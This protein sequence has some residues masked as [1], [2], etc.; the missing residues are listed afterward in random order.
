MNAR[1]FL[2]RQNS[3]KPFR[4]AT[5]ARK[6][7]SI[8]RRPRRQ[9]P[10]LTGLVPR[11]TFP[12]HQTVWLEPKEQDRL[13]R[14]RSLSDARQGNYDDAIEG[15]TILI[16]RNPEGATD[17]NN[18]GLVHFQQG[19]LQAALDDYT[20]AIKLN[21]RLASAYNNRANY[22]AAQG[23]LAEAIADYETAIDLDPTNIRAWINQGIT[24]R[25]LEMYAQ[26]IENFEQA[27]QI[28]HLL[29]QNPEVS[30][31]L[32]AHI[33]GAQGR[34]HHLAGDWNL[35]IADYYRALDRFF[36]LELD[37]TSHRLQTQI[38]LWLGE[39]QA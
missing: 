37:L 31:R 5:V 8:A 38:I 3:D 29:G 23:N 9:S 4:A 12:T 20:Q 2:N 6:G 34:T 1:T 19:Q 17:Y 21:P 16:D 14:Q 26:A 18:R 7:A 39:L 36:D 13:L 27:L 15:L 30:Q 10:A 25:D 32:E 33:Y 24:F 35:A 22:Y 28:N 11:R